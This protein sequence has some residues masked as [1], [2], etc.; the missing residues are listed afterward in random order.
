MKIFKNLL[1]KLKK[2]R[3]YDLDYLGEDL[4]IIVANEFINSLGGK[5]NIKNI[6]SCTTRLRVSLNSNDINI[7]NLILNGAKKVIKLDNLNY[8]IVVGMKA[9]KLE[10]IIKKYLG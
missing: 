10:E 4:L 9:A 6:Y 2:R 3:K 7:E 5:N 8:Q 1:S